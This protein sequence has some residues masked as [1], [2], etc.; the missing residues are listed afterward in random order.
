MLKWLTASFLLKIN[1]TK[2]FELVFWAKN[3]VIPKYLP[4]KKCFFEI[5]PLISPEN[6]LVFNNFKAVVKHA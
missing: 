1:I 5:G 3:S 4:F 2:L 6:F